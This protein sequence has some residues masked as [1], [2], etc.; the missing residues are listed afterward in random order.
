MA[1][2][3]DMGILG[4]VCQQE[5]KCVMFFIFLVHACNN[6]YASG[7]RL[8][9]AYRIAEWIDLLGIVLNV[10]IGDIHNLIHES[11]FSCEIPVE[12][13][14]GIKERWLTMNVCC[15]AVP[16]VLHHHH[17]HHCHAPNNHVG[18]PDIHVHN[19][20]QVPTGHLKYVE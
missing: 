6:E 7:I 11:W 5:Q 17:H 19:H 9:S 10:G 12:R 20:D 4:K 3:V 15:R 16:Q 2:S 18:P 1:V 13:I 14:N 8:S